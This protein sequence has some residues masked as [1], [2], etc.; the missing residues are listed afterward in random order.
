MDLN[1]RHVRAFVSVAH[2][3]SF[4]RAAAL[5]NL[6]QPALTVQIRRLEEALAVRLLDRKLV[7]AEP[8]SLLLRTPH[9]LVRGGNLRLVLLGFLLGDRLLRLL[10]S[11]RRRVGDPDGVA[12]PRR[13]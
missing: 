1:L 2:L 11:R 13:G 12:R 8:A 10:S 9:L 7:L 6:S 4:T 5:L 3:R